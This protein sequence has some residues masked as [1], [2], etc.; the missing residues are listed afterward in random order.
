M[1]DNLLRLTAKE[2]GSTVRLVKT[3]DAG[4]IQQNVQISYTLDGQT[5]VLNFGDT[6]EL[7]SAQY[8]EFSGVNSSFSQSKGTSYIH[9]DLGGTIAASGSVM[10]LVDGTGMTTVIPSANCFAGLFQGCE[11]LVSAPELP[12]TT[13]K[14]ACY[15]GMFENCIN[16]TSAPELPATQLVPYCYAYMFLGCTSLTEAPALPST[17]L[18]NY[19][20]YS[21]FGNC[22][23]LTTAPV[24]P[25]TTLSNRCYASMFSGCANLTSIEVLFEAWSPADATQLWV[26]GLPTSGTFICPTALD[27][28]TE[29]N[30]MVPTGWTI[31]NP[32]YLE[33]MQLDL[34]KEYDHTREA[35]ITSPGTIVG[36]R[37]SHVGTTMN[38]TVLYNDS[39]V[40]T[41]KTIT[42]HYEITGPNAA[43]YRAPED[44][45][46]TGA[47]ITAHQLSAEGIVV[48]TS[49]E[50]DATTGAAITQQPTVVGVYA[51]DEVSLSAT[52][53]YDNKSAGE[54]KTITITY[55]ISGAQAANYLAPV[56][57]TYTTEGVITKKTLT[58]TNLEV[59]TEKDYDLSD[60]AHVVQQPTVGGIIAGDNCSVLTKA[61][62]DSKEV[63]TGK[64]IVVEYSLTGTDAANYTIETDSFAY[65]MEGKILGN[66]IGVR[67][68][69]IIIDTVRV[70]DGTTDA[71]VHLGYIITGVK[72]GHDVQVIVKADYDDMHAGTDKPI[73][74]E[75]LLEGKDAAKYILENGD[76]VYTYTLHG[77]I[78]PRQL[79]AHGAEVKTEK[80]YDGTDYAMVLV[81]ATLHDTV[82]GDMVTLQTVA[83]YEDEHAG[84]EKYIYID[85]Q[86]SGDVADYLAPLMDSIAYCA[87]FDSIRMGD[88]SM[89]GTCEGYNGIVGATI[90][91][92][93]PTT[94]A[95]YWDHEA[96]AVGL[97]DQEGTRFMPDNYKEDY[98]EFY[99]ELPSSLHDG[100]Y[101]GTVRVYGQIEGYYEDVDMTM[102][103]N[104]SPELLDSIFYDVISIDNRENRFFSYQW[105]LNGEPIPGATLP[106]YQQEGG[107]NGEYS[108]LLNEGTESELMTC[109]RYFYLDEEAPA[110]VRKAVEGSH[111]VVIT[112]EGTTYYINGQTISK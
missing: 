95:L 55:S 44:S 109:S 76:S 51:G 59:Q 5:A 83:N 25:A 112:P 47:C 60:S 27:P 74:Y 57:S 80:L 41:D 101:H 97:E 111:V 6:L 40:G 78:L 102:Q 98:Y 34:C 11:A 43:Q 7:D 100:I 46:I 36:M 48:T 45:I 84:T 33:G 13:L 77:T 49:R 56:D 92:G 66:V 52:A 22:S 12:A 53:N 91:R 37:D 104:G 65:S 70:Y 67:Q 87:I 19:C 88:F 26:S 94:Y 17:Q 1:A 62:Y 89:Y 85:Y 8:V 71:K 68:S 4:T 14:A 73:T 58:L 107:L 99:M 61:Y 50:Y 29:N 79:T 15:D 90:L 72:E 23:A 3:D 2:N 81:E 31:I 28:L 96:H 18:A 105:Y 38:Y 30:N 32:L 75:I 93:E 110:R 21:M 54:N 42:I 35:N 103:V 86:I 64:T 24:L 39:A 16:L 82:A 69:S 106:Y 10:S 20:Y 108:V 63:G 9:F